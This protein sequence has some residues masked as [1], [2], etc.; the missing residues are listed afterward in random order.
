MDESMSTSANVTYY[1]VY[2]KGVFVK[3]HRQNALCKSK[4]HE[5]LS[6]YS[7]VEDFTVVVRWP[8]EDEADHLGE[9][10]PLSKFLRGKQKQ[11]EDNREVTTGR[12][13]TWDEYFMGM[14]KYIATRSK[15]RSTKI[16]AVLV[17]P[18][19]EI[20][21][22]GYNDF[23]RK[24]NDDVDTRR[25]RPAKY[26]FSEHAERNSIYNASRVGTPTEGCILYVSGRPPCADCAR[27]II[28]AGIKE[29][30]VETMEHKSRPEMDWEANTKAAMEM[31]QEAGIVVRLVR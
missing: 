27:A 8:D 20:R 13:E 2:R 14:A 23:P 21:S 30:I 15:D 9:P 12:R 6:Q 26:L 31:L 16:G 7:P 22:T 3:E 25:E 4:I 29:V 10:I 1:R 18:S 11:S 5:E 24:V 28:Q 17:G 19:K